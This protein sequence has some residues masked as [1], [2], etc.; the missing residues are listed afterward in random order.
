MLTPPH[1]DAFLLPPSSSLL[2]LPLGP[3]LAPNPSACV[4]AGSCAV[5][6]NS[7][8]KAGSRAT[9]QDKRLDRLALPALPCGAFAHAPEKSSHTL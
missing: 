9:P 5:A 4:G 3:A 8:G 6:E 2:S 7:A 1:A